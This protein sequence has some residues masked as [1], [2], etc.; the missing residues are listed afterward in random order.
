MFTNILCRHVFLFSNN[1]ASCIISRLTE[2]LLLIE[3]EGQQCAYNHKFN[4]T[5]DVL[6]CYKVQSATKV[7]IL[8]VFSL[9]VLDFF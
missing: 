7:F 8:F 2:Y 6:I 1:R 5:H 9:T 4:C 3:N